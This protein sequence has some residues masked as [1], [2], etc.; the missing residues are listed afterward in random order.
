LAIAYSLGIV[1][2]SYI[3]IGDILE[4]RELTRYRVNLVEKRTQV[5]N[6][7][8]FRNCRIQDRTRRELMEKLSKGQELSEEDKSELEAMLGRKLQSN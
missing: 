8:D 5:K 7:I 2:G 4:L 6:E 3:P 1:K